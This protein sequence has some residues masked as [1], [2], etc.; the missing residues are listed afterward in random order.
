M[1]SNIYQRLD[2]VRQ[3]VDYIQK[4]A[5]VQGYSAITHDQ[6]TAYVRQPLIDNGIMVVPRQMGSETVK[7]GETRNGHPVVRYEARYE[8]DFVNQ[9]DP[10][11]I[12]T[13]PIESHANDQGDKA[14][15]KA[16][17]YAVK[18]AML[19][20]FNI[21][22]G[23]NEEGRLDVAL[24]TTAITAEKYERLQEL[25]EETG[26]DPERF[27][28]YVS[29]Q[30]GIAIASFASMDEATYQWAV[31]ALTAKRDRQNREAEEAADQEAEGEPEA[32]KKGPGD[33]EPPETPGHNPVG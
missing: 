9:S 4:D 32:P 14:P 17:S 30:L 26:T 25:V 8:V 3:A 16:L 11:Q 15:G 1:A 21:E 24:R 18:Y 13:V 12:V 22:T 10:T 23:E 33:K 19:K 27:R 31:K 20:L 2:A 5:Y 28:Q 6:V 7:I 29:D